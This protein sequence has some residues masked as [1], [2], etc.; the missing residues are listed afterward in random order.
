MANLQDIYRTC[1]FA[2]KQKELIRTDQTSQSYTRDLLSLIR[3]SK[4]RVTTAVTDLGYVPFI[5]E[6]DNVKHSKL[7][8]MS[9]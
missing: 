1:L 5:W 2:D 8:G 6:V 7:L 3:L 4:L 9:L